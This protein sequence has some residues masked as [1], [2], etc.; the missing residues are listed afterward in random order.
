MI[1]IETIPCHAQVYSLKNV[2]GLRI[3]VPNTILIMLVFYIMS[4]I[5]FLKHL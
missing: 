4:S 1:L 2:L 3:F 5:S